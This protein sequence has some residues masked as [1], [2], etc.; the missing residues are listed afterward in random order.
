[1][2]VGGIDVVGV[3]DGFGRL[4]PTDSY[5]GRFTP[6]IEGLP[7]PKGRGGEES[8][9][10]PHRTLL[11]DDGMLSI[12]IGGF[13]VRSSD[14]LVLV[15][16]GLGPFDVG[17]MQGGQLLIE[18]AALGVDP[19]DITDVVLTH[20]HLDH[21]G[22]ATRKGRVVFDRATYRCDRR[23]WEYFVGSD[24]VVTRKLRPL[25]D[26]LETWDASGPLLPGIDTLHAP[27]HTP[28]STIVVISSGV[29]RAMLLGD[30][31]HCPVEL[32]DDEW[33]G[34]ADVDPDLALRTRTALVRELEHSEIPAAAAHFP[35]LQFGRLLSGTGNRAWV[36]D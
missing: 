17:T 34:M 2:K 5:A 19:V 30:V 4:V 16:C 28:G 25:Q 9:W 22:W 6:R 11:D 20:L 10:E 12:A 23:D 32:L 21:V 1:V 29:D 18:L 31:V 15:D 8:D 13:L 36:F 3:T 33:A 14:R 24:E 7:P 26:H 27:G 35:G